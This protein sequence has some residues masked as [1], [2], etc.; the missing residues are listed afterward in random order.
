MSVINL[1]E[2]Q[3]KTTSGDTSLKFTP[4]EPSEDTLGGVTLEEKQQIAT[5]KQDIDELKKTILE[6]QT[7]LNQ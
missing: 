3:F 6:I 4:T 7:L 1:S 2:I 5:N